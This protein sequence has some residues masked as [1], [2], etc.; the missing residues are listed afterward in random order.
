MGSQRFDDGEPGDEFPVTLVGGDGFLGSGQE[1]V[2]AGEEIDYRACLE[3]GLDGA[4][5]AADEIRVV[6]HVRAVGSDGIELCAELGEGAGFAGGIVSAAMDGIA[7]ANA[8]A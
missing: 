2:A 7:C 6:T 4:E 8:L 5:G 3:S 1:P